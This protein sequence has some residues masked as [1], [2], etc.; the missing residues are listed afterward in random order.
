MTDMDDAGARRA[1][2]LTGR[3]E[4]LRARL[5][6]LS[7]AMPL[8]QRL[9]GGLSQG[10]TSALAA[11]VAYLPTQALGLQEG[12]WGAITAMAVTQT[13]LGATRNNG[14]DQFTG[15]AIGGVVGVA[16]ALTAGQHLAGYVM[17]VVLSMLACWA[18]NIA[19]ASRLAGITATIIL[20]VPH[21]GTPGHMLVSR[22]GEVGW[23]VVVALCLVWARERLLRGEAGETRR[24]T[25]RSAR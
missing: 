12:F 21:T 24:G 5:S 9:R 8:P 13:E 16:V 22:V 15:A 1:A 2:G 17:A 4:G 23:G 25:D 11:V 18:V 6:D 20:L 19:S 3:I 10:V 7:K 14:R